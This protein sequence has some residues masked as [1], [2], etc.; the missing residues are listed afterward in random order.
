MKAVCSWERLVTASRSHGV[1]TKK[2]GID[3]L[4]NGY[5]IGK[6]NKDRFFDDNLTT[7]QKLFKLWRCNYLNPLGRGEYYDGID[8]AL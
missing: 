7:Q 5:N 4:S 3:K 2:A 8:T 1:T 6:E